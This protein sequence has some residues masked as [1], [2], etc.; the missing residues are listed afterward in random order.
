MKTRK[1]SVA[2]GSLDKN[3]FVRNS[4]DQDRVTALW[5][6][7]ESKVVLDPMLVFPEYEIVNGRIK[8]VVGGTKFIIVDGRHRY[9]A[10]DICG[11]KT[12][13]V[14]VITEGVETESELIALAYKRNIG[15]ALPP[16]QKDTEHTVEA[17]LERGA[18]KKSIGEL[19]G[20]PPALARKYVN[21]VELR[22]KRTK[23]KRASM[24]VAEGQITATEAAAKHGVPMD[25]LQEAIGGKKPGKKGRKGDVEDVQKSLT[26][27]YKGLSSKN[28]AMLRSLLEKFDDGDVSA[29]EVV[30]VLEHMDRLVAQQ[31]KNLADWRKRFDAKQKPGNG[32]AGK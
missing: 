9:E 8:I 6:L 24:E 15:G 16:T 21:S 13:D 31:A 30:E 5:E 10:H 17:M 25:Q 23:L 4:L 26:L 2:I 14:E 12:V 29:T 22:L 32:K 19:L 28:G 27:T 20:L 7:L 3:L 1:M 11:H 18:S